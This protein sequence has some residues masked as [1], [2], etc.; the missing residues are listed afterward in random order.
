MA[1]KKPAAKAAPPR[2]RTSNGG[3][4]RNIGFILIVAP[5]L[6][7]FMPTV[8]FLAF[9]LLPTFVA[10]VV[11]R[12]PKRY[13][14]ITVGGLNFS[15]AFPHLLT[16]WMGEHS[17]A[18]ALTLL[19]DVLVLMMIFGAAGLGW[20]L[21]LSMPTMVMT[22]LSMTSTRRLTTLKAKQKQLITAWGPEVASSTEE[23]AVEPA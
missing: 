14:A 15:G 5:M 2:K 13:A 12:N 21:A 11:D 1:K 18:A 22:A 17:V 7:L 19:S 9:A 3:I 6:F 16:L 20:V 4:M 10:L 8:L 23:N